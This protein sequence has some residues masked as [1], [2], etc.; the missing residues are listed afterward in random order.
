MDEPQTIRT[1]AGEELVVLS[2]QDYDQLMS[3]LAEAEEE[4]ADIATLDQRKSEGPDVGRQ[5]LP[6]DVSRRLLEGKGRLQ[7]I[8][9]WRG[10]ARSA[11]AEKLQLDEGVLARI[12]ADR[13]PLDA[14]TAGRIAVLLDVPAYW[15]AG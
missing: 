1:Q 2:R 12:E 5:V 13:L 3:A 9:E 8:R 4:L 15:I 11:I 7:A 14:A 6:A 10:L